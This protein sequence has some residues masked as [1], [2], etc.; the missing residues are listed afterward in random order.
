MKVETRRKELGMRDGTPQPPT[1][2]QGTHRGAEGG[3]PPIPGGDGEVV[4]G[5][6][7]T[8][9]LS[10][11]PHPQLP[12][13]WGDHKLPCQRQQG[14]GWCRATAKGPAPQGNG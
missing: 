7:L 3:H 4:E 1:P 13:H 2:A 5:D 11:L 12:F 6:V 9:Q 14:P 8:V 10:I